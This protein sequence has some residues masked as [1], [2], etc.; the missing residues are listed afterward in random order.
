[1]DTTPAIRARARPPGPVPVPQPGGNLLQGLYCRQLSVHC[2]KIYF[3]STVQTIKY[4]LTGTRRS[5]RFNRTYYVQHNIKDENVQH[6]NMRSSNLSKKCLK[7]KRS[8]YINGGGF[9]K[10]SY[11]DGSLS[12]WFCAA[13][14]KKRTCV[15]F[16]TIF[17]LLFTRY[18]PME[19]HVPLYISIEMWF[20]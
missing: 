4:Y 9:G 6:R 20:Q 15:P 19:I 16:R 5:T 8:T 3:S 17:T 2:G 18:N 14:T 10:Q 13:P 12:T 11:F 7:I 1:M